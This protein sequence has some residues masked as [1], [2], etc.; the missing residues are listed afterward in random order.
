M[1]FN[2]PWLISRRRFF[3]AT[4]FDI[5]I[6]YFFH[7]TIFFKKF[8]AYPNP[9][10]TI[11]ISFF[12]IISSY[13]LGRYMICKKFNIVEILKAFLNSSNVFFSCNVVYLSINIS[14]KILKFI[15]CEDLIN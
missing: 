1:K 6:I 15:N 5:L 13:I 8:N 11:S 2:I 9:I 3:I 12:W 7:I 10:V 4:L 14:N